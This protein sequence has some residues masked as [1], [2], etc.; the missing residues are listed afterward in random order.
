M[1]DIISGGSRF[2]GDKKAPV[3]KVIKLNT[4]SSIG[5][6]IN[7]YDDRNIGQA[8]VTKEADYEEIRQRIVR[9][10]IR[11]GLLIVL[12]IALIAGAVVLAMHLLDGY[13]YTSYSVT[14][15]INREDTATSQYI[16]YQGGYIKY[17]NDGVSYY[18][19][20]GKAIWNQ[21]YSMQKPQVK[22]CEECVA[23]GDINGN[24][25]YVFNK[26][27]LLGKIDTSLVISQIEVAANGA[28]VAVLEDNE[29]NYINMYSK[30]GTK[31][32]SIKTTV[33]GDGYPLD[34]S[35]SNDAAKLIASYVYVSG[36]DIKTNVVFYNFSEVGQNETERVV[37]GF[38]HYNDTLVGDVQFLSNNIA[39]A[40]GENVISIYKI[41][42]Y[43]SL[44]HTINIDNEIQKIFCSDQY[45]GLVLDN[46]E[47][48]D[49]YKLV[50]YNISGKHIFDTTFGIQYTDM[51]FDG[52]SVV[53]SNA[54]TFVL[55]NMSGK[56]LADISFDMP[57]INVLP[58]GA[59]G[60]YTIV[61]SKYI[62]S[63]KLK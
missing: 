20:K 54:S 18:T 44:E 56:K 16:A 48:G 19:D 27:G 34:V 28:V 36:E 4:D 42:E 43:P 61:N 24:T 31:I 47:S 15:S 38:N 21:T 45:I 57:V 52:K 8:A 62:Q 6:N 59:R 5:N 25:V 35:I 1:A 3:R 58:T 17:S 41:K 37:G 39:V 50:V 13:S 40:V 55:L 7:N 46:S 29:A 33:S 32:Y 2:T 26:S 30:E 53:I 51:Q 14:G 23:V 10:R 63:I 11:M 22:M 9:H 60:S 12:V 49:P